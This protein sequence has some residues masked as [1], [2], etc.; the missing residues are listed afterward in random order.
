MGSCNKKPEEEDVETGLTR[1]EARLLRKTWQ[2]YCLHNRDYGFIIFLSFFIK[3][4]GALQLFQR[5]RDKT[6]GKLPDDP[7]FRAHAAAVTFQLTSMVDNADDAVLL[8]AL[9]RKNAKAHTERPGVMPD[10]FR[11]LG[12][13]VVEVLHTRHE[14][15][16]TPAAVLAWEKLFDYM[17][18]I[19]KQVYEE[20]KV[21]IKSLDVDG[22]IRE[23][24][25][26][27]N[28]GAT[29]GRAS[30][31]TT[32]QLRG[33]RSAKAAQSPGE[34]N[35]GTPKGGKS[36]AAATPKGGQ[37]PTTVRADKS[38]AKSPQSPATPKK[39]A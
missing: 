11:M 24:D 37:T 27:G 15:N 17:A 4:R 13:T 21:E 36:P 22:F 9:I 6:L 31:S 3:T 1:T 10:H 28:K 19:T 23:P 30:G 38:P 8:E 33:K 2:Y 5:F 39:V 7:Q 25:A 34:S 29:G 32:P 16:M 14:T 26:D 20:Q 12:K 35:R 18:R